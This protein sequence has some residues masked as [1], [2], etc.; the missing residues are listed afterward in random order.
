MSDS[1]HT[2]NV[3]AVVTGSSGFVGSAIALRFLHLGQ[4]VRLPLRTPQQAEAW[5]KQYGD[6]YKGKIDP[7][8]L[9]GA[10]SEKGVFDRILEGADVV[11]HAASPAKFDIEVRRA[12]PRSLRRR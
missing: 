8:V 6:K 11:V 5:L 2:N 7:V 3:L 4:S 12:L 9:E 10:M 1:T